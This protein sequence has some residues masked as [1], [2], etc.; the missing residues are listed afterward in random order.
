MQNQEE[1]KHV[2]CTSPAFELRGP[3]EHYQE[4]SNTK[5]SSL[6]RLALLA[7]QPGTIDRAIYRVTP[8]PLENAIEDRSKPIVLMPNTTLKYY[9]ICGSGVKTPVHAVY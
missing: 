3:W 7:H 4:H 8:E 9:C 2:K 1:D 6:L 5:E